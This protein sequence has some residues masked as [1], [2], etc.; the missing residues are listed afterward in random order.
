MI[1]S[2]KIK[3]SSSNEIHLF[4][5][6]VFWVAYEQSAYYFHLKKGY[7]PTK[8]FIKKI[9]S[10]VV[11]VGFPENALATMDRKQSQESPNHIV[12]QAEELIEEEAFLEWKNRIDIKKQNVNNPGCETP[13]DLAV[14]ERIKSFELSCATPMEC[15]M[16]L[17]DLKRNL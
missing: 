10:E 17:F 7:K 11:S 4:K 13:V 6:G 8:K 5:E 15:M 2:D 1:L 3:L 12:L 9:N 16:F 14:I